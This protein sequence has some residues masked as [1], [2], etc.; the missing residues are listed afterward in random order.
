MNYILSIIFFILYLYVAYLFI[1]TYK[2]F[3]GTNFKI[4][5]SFYKIRSKNYFRILFISEFLLLIIYFIFGIFIIFSNEKFPILIYIIPI[6]FANSNGIVLINENYISTIF[7]TVST[8]NIN[9]IRIENDAFV[10]SHTRAQLIFFMN[11]KKKKIKVNIPNRN[12]DS[13]KNSLRELGY[14]VH[15]TTKTS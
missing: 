8:K 13:V 1:I 9:C 4:V 10:S 6:L 11:N 14:E 5:N 3:K 12:I 7:K 15:I 2:T